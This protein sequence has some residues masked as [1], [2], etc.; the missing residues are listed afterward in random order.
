MERSSY[1][2]KSDDLNVKYVVVQTMCLIRQVPIIINHTS[3]R[4]GLA[5]NATEEES[6]ETSLLRRKR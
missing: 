2:V 5:R 6:K 1:E 3:M 4:A